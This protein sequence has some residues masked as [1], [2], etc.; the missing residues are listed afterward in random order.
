MN[1]REP[2]E[3]GDGATMTGHNNLT[4][5][6]TGIENR[7]PLEV[8]DIMCDRIKH[9][10]PVTDIQAVWDQYADSESVLATGDPWKIAAWFRVEASRLALA[11]QLKSEQGT[12]WR[13]FHCGDVFTDEAEAREHF[14]D[15][16]DD[17]P[18]C[19]VTAERYRTVER[20]L[21]GYQNE[22]D[23]TAR[24]FYD[25]GHR[26]AVAERGAEQKGYDRGIADAKA[27]PD[28]VGLQRAITQGHIDIAKHFAREAFNKA[29]DGN[30]AR[31]AL[32]IALSKMVEC[33]KP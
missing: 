12:E 2:G 6:I 24:T 16:M 18:I 32:D 4:R 30:N 31:H 17:E 29:E 5:P 8:F 27:H 3:F 20:E 1:H 26:A 9:A 10:L 7:T 11:L 23:A 21:V 14:G 22:S 25:I 15:T 19:Q 13:C 33:L 28:E